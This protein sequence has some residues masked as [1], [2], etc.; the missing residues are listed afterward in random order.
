MLLPR[1]VVRGVAAYISEDDE[2]E[3]TVDCT[4]D[5]RRHTVVYSCTARRQ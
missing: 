5:H 2:R 4:R 1:C 3:H